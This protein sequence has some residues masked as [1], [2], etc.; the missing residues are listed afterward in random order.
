MSMKSYE[1]YVGKE[2][3]DIMINEVSNRQK[4]LQRVSKR[5]TN[6]IAQYYQEISFNNLQ[7]NP[8][9]NRGSENC[10]ESR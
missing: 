1:I 3:K 5:R 4:I 10:Y 7:E 6:P 2:S 9:K 8:K